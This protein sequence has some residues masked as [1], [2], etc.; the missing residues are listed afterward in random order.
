[1]KSFVFFRN[2]DN[3]WVHKC[4]R[5]NSMFNRANQK[6]TQNHIHT[7]FYLFSSFVTKTF[8]FKMHFLALNHI[9][10]ANVF[11]FCLTPRF[12]QEYF[13]ANIQQTELLWKHALSVVKI[14]RW[15]KTNKKKPNKKITC[16][17]SYDKLS[18]M[19]ERKR[20]TK[21]NRLQTMF[22][23]NAIQKQIDNKLHFYF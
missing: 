22:Q 12:K 8:K 21:L 7:F 3:L 20:K 13:F 18:L 17:I 4:L 10:F 5:W 14:I 6:I 15:G 1:M 11:E 19:R 23:I 16:K 9:F 2:F